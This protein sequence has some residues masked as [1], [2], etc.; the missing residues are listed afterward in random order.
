MRY[1]EPSFATPANYQATRQHSLNFESWGG[2]RHSDTEI[3]PQVLASVIAFPKKA[4]AWFT[5]KISRKEITMNN[6]HNSTNDSTGATRSER[7]ET[8]ALSGNLHATLSTQS[9]DIVVRASERSDV[10]VTLTPRSAKDAY[11]LE[12]ADIVFDKENNELRVAT[13][14]KGISISSRGLRIGPK[15]SWFDF[16]SSDLDVILEVPSSSS[17]EI[18]TVS[19][20]A[21]LHGTLGDVQVKSVSGDVVAHDSS[22]ALDVQTASGDV[23]SGTVITRLTCKSASGDVSCLSAATKTEIYSASGDITLSVNQPGKVVVR[24][25]SG[26]VNVRVKKGLAVDISGNS[27]SGDMGSNIDLDGVGTTSSDEEVVIKVTTVSGDIRIDKA[28]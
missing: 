23:V 15:K 14:P 21:S 7:T 4:S 28:S 8:F 17:C 27:V 3:K 9:G 12:T 1:L 10:K 13:L 22:D 19:G 24:N 6:G 5:I 16:G 20:D 25:V 26:D 11:L 2:E 18:S